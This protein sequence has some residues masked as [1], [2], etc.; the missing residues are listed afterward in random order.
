MA[1]LITGSEGALG[2]FFLQNK[3]DTDIVRVV[4]SR[5]VNSDNGFIIHGDLRDQLFVKSIFSQYDIT[6]I[7]HLAARWNGRNKLYYGLGDNL[8]M[9]MNLLNGMSKQVRRFDY[10]SSSIVYEKDTACES[11]AAMTEY[12]ENLDPSTSYGM[13][14][15][16]S[17]K[18]IQAK[19]IENGINYA[20]WRPIHIVSPFEPYNPGFSHLVTDMYHKIVK[21]KQKI[22]PNS[23]SSGRKIEF[24]W[25]G[26][27]VKCIMNSFG[28]D[29]SHNQIFNISANTKYFSSDVVQIILETAAEKKL[30]D[31][32]V[33]FKQINPSISLYPNKLKSV[34][35]MEITTSLKE[36]I[37]K[38]FQVKEDNNGI[39]KRTT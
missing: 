4:Q 34:L 13:G 37:N 23:F 6:H 26:D 5:H 11:G 9:T 21:L 14:K 7:L 35:G 12:N 25:G 18:L 22:D 31:W 27:I 1:I 10:L 20:I 2:S 29:K 38:Y 30:I 24:T 15:Y 32:E 19:C 8:A 39:S 28:N 17:E 36:C 33:S 16:Y 3:F